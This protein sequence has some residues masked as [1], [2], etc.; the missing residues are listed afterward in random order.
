MSGVSNASG[1]AGEEHMIDFAKLA[2]E[3]RAEKCAN[4]ASSFTESDIVALMQR[5]AA[6]ALASA[7]AAAEAYARENENYDDDGVLSKGVPDALRTLL[8]DPQS[9]APE[10]WEDVDDEWSEAIKAAFPTRSGSHAQYGVAMKMV[11]HR[12]SK[13]ALVAL[14]NWLLVKAD[15]S[16]ERGWA[17]CVRGIEMSRDT[18]RP[19]TTSRAACEVVL[20]DLR[21]L[22]ALPKVVT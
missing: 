22:A 19:D 20:A 1:C 3:F 16:E 9:R 7:I 13:I 5:V 12:H 21:K 14:V 11:G 17:D 2:R 15:A 10:P 8:A 18:F 4:A 6:E